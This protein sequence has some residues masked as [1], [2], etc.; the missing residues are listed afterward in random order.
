MGKCAICKCRNCTDMNHKTIS[1]LRR[2][3]SSMA[4]GRRVVL[5]AWDMDRPHMPWSID[6]LRESVGDHDCIYDEYDRCFEC[7]APKLKVVDDA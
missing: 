3:L 4:Y 7:D 5:R 6:Q 2:K 1:E